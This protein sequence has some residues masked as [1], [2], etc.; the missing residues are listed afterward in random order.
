MANVKSG[1]FR[2]IIID[3]C[4]QSRRG[5][6]TMEIME[7]C[8]EALERRCEPLITATN[9]IRNDILSI[10]N[11]WN[12][13][14]EPIKVGRNIRYRYQN[15]NFSIFRS[16]LNE[17]EIIE[18]SHAVSL[19]RRFEG[20]PG[21]GWVDE[22]NVHLQ[23]TINIEQK[24]FV[25]FDENK[26]LRGM[27]YFTPLFECISRKEVIELQYQ[28]YKE[29]KANIYVVHP[30][31]L[32]E[33][34]QRWFLFAF[35]NKYKDVTIFSLDRIRGIRKTSDTYIKNETIDFEH[36]FDERIGVS[37]IKYEE[38][39][40]VII[41]VNAEQLQYMLTKP[42]H[43]TQEVIEYEQNGG[44]ILSIKVKPNFELI[45]CLLSFGDRVTVL[46]PESLR[47]KMKRRI[48]KNLSNYQ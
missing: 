8:N 20:M 12:I 31:Y 21:F 37:S 40:R 38:A 1:A 3:R 32:K 22:L 41:R 44:A 23:S 39:I 47:E 45:Q 16:S 9:T 7:K 30:Y 2:E 35:N 18:L 6:S 10:E 17:E 48:K 25:G 33:Y 26:Q 28:S 14:V 36:Y 27:E 29:D 13:V 19:L 24:S 43:H 5:Y 46:G 15:P 4:L 42:L 34:N 11:R